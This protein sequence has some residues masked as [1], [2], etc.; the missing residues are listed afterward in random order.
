LY[1]STPLYLMDVEAPVIGGGRANVD[2]FKGD[3]L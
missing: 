2:E 3:R 1:H